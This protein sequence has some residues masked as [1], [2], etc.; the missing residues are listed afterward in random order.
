MRC[1][2]KRA[3]IIDDGGSFKVEYSV[4]FDGVK[5]YEDR[6]ILGVQARTVNEAMFN[7]LVVGREYQ[8]C[9]RPCL[10]ELSTYAGEHNHVGLIVY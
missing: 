6:D 4:L 10:E 2:E 9:F 8:F 1:I 7:A 5:I 3:E